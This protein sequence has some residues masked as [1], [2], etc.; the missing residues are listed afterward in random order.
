MWRFVDREIYE[1]DPSGVRVL[2]LPRRTQLALFAGALLLC[3][4]TLL[5]LAAAGGFWWL[6]QRELAGRV[7]EAEGRAPVARTGTERHARELQ[8]LRASW[9][10]RLAELRDRTTREAETLRARLQA[11]ELHAARTA[12]ERDALRQER[13][14]L[15]ARLER[16]SARVAQMAAGNPAAA[17]GPP[18]TGTT[19][20]SGDGGRAA[21]LEARLEQMRRHLVATRLALERLRRERDRLGEQYRAALRAAERAA[22]AERGRLS[23]ELERLRVGNRQAAAEIAALRRRLG[24]L[25]GE[26]E[27]A[28]AR[29]EAAERRSAGLDAALARA[30]SGIAPAAGGSGA[31]APATT[32]AAVGSEP[33]AAGV[34]GTLLPEP[35][36]PAPRRSPP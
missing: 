17:P 6:W 2:P 33:V 25:A 19:A 12:R 13:E 4:L 27:R 23:A 22:E 15:A 34:L 20:S 32:T 21:R 9:E 8:E 3:A 28:L 11:A 16:L 36:R 18:S 31:D 7:G 26:R 5:S 35:P 1:R 30:Q 14:E 24:E 10:R 29:A